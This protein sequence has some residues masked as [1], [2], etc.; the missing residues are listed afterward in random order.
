MESDTLGAKLDE[1]SKAKLPTAKIQREVD[2]NWKIF[3]KFNDEVVKRTKARQSVGLAERKRLV[4]N[5]D[6]LENPPPRS[7]CR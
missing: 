1:A 3:Q 7:R 6:E 5:K 4:L 2:Q